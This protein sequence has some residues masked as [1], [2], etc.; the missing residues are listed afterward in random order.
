LTRVSRP[1]CCPEHVL[2]RRGELGLVDRRQAWAPRTRRQRLRDFSTAVVEICTATNQVFG[3]RLQSDRG[4][5]EVLLIPHLISRTTA[6]YRGVFCRMPTNS[7][8][9]SPSNWTLSPRS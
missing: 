3:C 6:C 4:S 7:L 9:A 8:R 1:R 2:M 5:D